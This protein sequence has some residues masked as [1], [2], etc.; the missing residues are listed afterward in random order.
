MHPRFRRL[1]YLATLLCLAGLGVAVAESFPPP[2]GGQFRGDACNR[3]VFRATIPNTVVEK[4]QASGSPYGAFR[5]PIAPAGSQHLFVP[6][7]TH[8]LY[9]LN[10]ANGSTAWH[11]TPAQVKFQWG[12]ASQTDASGTTLFALGEA[13]LSPTQQGTLICAFRDGATAPKLLW[14]RFLPTV[15]PWGDLTLGDGGL[16]FTAHDAAY[17]QY[18]LI[19]LNAAN[20]TLRFSLP[21]PAGSWAQTIKPAVDART[22]RAAVVLNDRLLWCRSDT[23][24]VLSEL[25]GIFVTSPVVIDTLTD[26]YYVKAADPATF[27]DQSLRC[28][29]GTQLV[30]DAKVTAGFSGNTPGPPVLD[31]GVVYGSTGPWGYATTLALDAATGAPLWSNFG[32]ALQTIFLSSNGRLVGHDDLANYW[33]LDAATG[34][35]LDQGNFSTLAFPNTDMEIAASENAF[36]VVGDG[37][38]IVKLAP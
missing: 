20:G 10:K 23:G 38:R 6:E 37:A 7:G 2:G 19:A 1:T 5:A 33:I 31:N 8:G 28:Y 22:H 16:F 24:A 29:R 17:A 13:N 26:L 18:T 25:T 32:P 30:W 27:T 12:L 3:G 21:L 11:F 34:N 14:Y 35:V 36:Y 15:F 4:W 9:A